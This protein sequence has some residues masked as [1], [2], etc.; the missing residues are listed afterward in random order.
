LV[1]FE[2]QAVFRRSYIVT[3][4]FPTSCWVSRILIRY[5]SRG[6]FREDV[7][8]DWHGTWSVGTSGPRLT[9]LC[10]RMYS[11]SHQVDL[12]L[13]VFIIQWTKQIEGR[14]VYSERFEL[15]CITDRHSVYI[16]EQESR[17]LS[18]CPVLISDA[19][20]LTLSCTELYSVACNLHGCCA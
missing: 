5:I 13:Y 17:V 14:R 11:R 9:S 6:L 4:N 16:R 15:A 1:H 18:E 20:F 8:R 19:P 12:L 10:F 3:S 7:K 2:F